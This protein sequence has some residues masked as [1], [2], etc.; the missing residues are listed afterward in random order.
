MALRVR[1]ET[2]ECMS[3][4]RC[5]ADHPEAFAFDDDELAVA[6]PAA[7]R[8]SDEVKVRVARNCPSRAIQL[9]ADD[10]TLVDV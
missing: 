2:D 8:L 5:V 10:G 7:D 3:A 4:G 9:V 6:T 1:I